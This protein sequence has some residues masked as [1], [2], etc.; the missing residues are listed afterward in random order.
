MSK[1][2]SISAFG[3]NTGFAFFF[4]LA[5]LAFVVLGCGGSKGNFKPAPAAFQGSW[6][7]SDGTTLNISSDSTVVYRSGGT[8]IDNGAAELDEDAKILKLS[9]LGVSL[10]EYKVDQM[11]AG[12]KMKLDGV[13]YQTGGGKG[14]GDGSPTPD[15]PTGSTD[16]PDMPSE[17]EQ[18]ALV[19]D[20]MEDFTEAVQK[21]D[22]TEFRD[23]NC[24]KDFKAT[25]SA[26]RF[27]QLFDSFIKQKKDLA[28]ILRATAD[29]TPKYS[30]A[31]SITEDNNVKLL[32]LKGSYD[33]TQKTTFELKYAK[34][35]G[36]WK[37]FGIKIRVEPVAK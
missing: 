5:A 37:I 21:G 15:G 12:G 22:F 24:S 19:G 6:T 35:D 20:T 34:E 32:N 9:F 1:N 36:D 13:V 31:P 2:T 14:T 30:P 23:S 11:P 26:E 18:D 3:K 10:K 16:D 8:K 4:A 17:T 25:V 28:P 33:T 7:G 27:N 29:L